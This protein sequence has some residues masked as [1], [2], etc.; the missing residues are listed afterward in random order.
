MMT[1]IGTITKYLVTLMILLLGKL[2]LENSQ[3]T[4]NYIPSPLP[5]DLNNAQR[6]RSAI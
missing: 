5:S 1:E 3:K 4:Q 2:V 6:W